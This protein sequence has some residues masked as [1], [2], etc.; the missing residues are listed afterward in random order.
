VI[1]HNYGSWRRDY[2]PGNF[3]VIRHNYGSWRRDLWSQHLRWLHL[4][5]WRRSRFTPGQSRLVALQIALHGDSAL[6]NRAEGVEPVA[7][8]R[9]AH[10]TIT[11]AAL[12][13]KACLAIARHLL[14]VY[15]LQLC[16]ATE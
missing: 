9:C 2:T 14:V 3:V 7:V 13:G 5:P 4:W 15:L 16:A 10:G 8:L 12:V 1:R 6:L 11:Q